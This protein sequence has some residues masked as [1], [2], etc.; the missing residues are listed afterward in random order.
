MT[1]VLRNASAGYGNVPVVRE[2]SM[3][4]ASGEILA[5]VGRN[6]VGKTTFAKAIAGLLPRLSGSMSFEGRDV[7]ALTARDM[8]R[9]GLGYVPQGR[10]IFPRLTVSENLR[11]GE[12][13]GGGGAAAHYDQVLAWFPRLA[14]RLSQAAGTLSGGEQQMLAIGRVLIG[15]PRLLVLDEP[16]DGVQPTIVQH[17]AEVIQEINEARAISVLL[18]EQNLDLIYMIADRCLVMEKGELVAELLPEDLIKPETA[19]RYLA[20]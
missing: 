14:E 12:A 16:S 8:A 7:T 4:M 11:I 3:A 2:V 20:I 5:I 13:V 17:I 10:G 15:N 6:G 19:Q 18:V 9:L 1:L